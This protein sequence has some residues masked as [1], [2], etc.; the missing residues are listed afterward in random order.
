M[1][2][3]IHPAILCHGPSSRA[4]ALTR[5]LA[6]AFV[7]FAVVLW[8]AGCDGDAGGAGESDKPTTL[9]FADTGIEGMEEMRR[10]YGP[11]VEQMEALS[12]VPVEFFPV[13][14]RT[15]AAVALEHGQ[16]DI[17]MAGPTEY[18]FIRSRQAVQPIVGI[19]RE[20]YYSVFI[21]PADSP[22][23]TMADLR[24]KTIAM[25]DT[26]STSGHVM[27]TRMLLDA[28]LDVDQDVTIR[29]LGNARVEALLNG[30]VDALA[31][32]VRV[33]AE[34]IEKRAPGKFRILAQSD[35]LPRDVMIARAGLSSEFVDELREKML[36]HGEELM[37][38]MLSPRQRNKYEGAKFVP[39]QDSDYDTLRRTHETLGLPYDN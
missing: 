15:V 25:K 33:W 20:A 32:G 17:V 11:F 9:R 5:S 34:Q 38:A 21:V 18:L 8:S 22:A 28:G 2:Q 7:L 4:G 3:R 1:S 35:P 19:E 30:E 29:L 12:G 24:G 16:V 14:N 27:P 6:L 23:K 31:D 36:E 26:G 37:A 10:A 39:V 13:N